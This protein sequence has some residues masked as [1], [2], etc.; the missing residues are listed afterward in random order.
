MLVTESDN[1]FCGGGVYASLDLCLHLVERMAGYEVA[2]QCSRAL[3]IDPPRTWQASFSVPLLHQDHHDRNIKKAQEYLHEHFN[4]VF[5]ID[6]LARRLGMSVRNFNRRFKQATGETP[7][8]Y[9]HKLRINCAKQLLETDYK[10]VQEVCYEVG[11]DDVQF[12]R[13]IFRRYTGLAPRAYKHRFGGYE[14]G[15][16]VGKSDPGNSL[17]G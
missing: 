4:T 13:K 6:D 17:P 10:S 2:K 14:P 1:F 15:L 8:G 3:L 11:Y 9:L 12:F 7:L 16:A 5:T